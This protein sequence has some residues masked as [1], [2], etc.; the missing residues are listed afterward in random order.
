MS[1]GSPKRLN[2]PSGL[3]QSRWRVPTPFHAAWASGMHPA[4]RSSIIT[5]D[6]WMPAARYFVEELKVDVNVRDAE[7]F[8][9]FHHA[10]AAAI[11]R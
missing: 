7:G 10:A 6:G 2:D 9:A 8:T 3:N 4:S 1:Y 5:L 11:T